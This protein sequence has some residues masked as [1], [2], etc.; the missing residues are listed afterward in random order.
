MKR[1]IGAAAL[2]A[3][4]GCGVAA[5]T[6]GTVTNLKLVPAHDVQ[7]QEDEYANHCGYKYRFLPTGKYGFGY[8]CDYEYD[9]TRHWTEHVPDCW[10]VTF[11]DESKHANHQCVE[12]N[13]YVELHVGSHFKMKEEG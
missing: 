2:L 4:A 13:E 1:L 7:K 8:G 9:H 6:E 11:A 12:K 10:Q 3:L 5:P